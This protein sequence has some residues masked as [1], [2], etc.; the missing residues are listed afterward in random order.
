MASVLKKGGQGR[1][2]LSNIATGQTFTIPKGMKI[3][4]VAVEALST[5]VGNISLGKSGATAE[6]V[7]SVA[8]P[9]TVGQVNQLT[10]IKNL[11]SLTSDYTALVTITGGK[12]VNLYVQ[13][14]KIN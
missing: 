11:Q 6:I 10:V 1:Y 13:L 5:T 2:V 12:L 7:G 4:Y 14:S 3:D 8:A 9:T